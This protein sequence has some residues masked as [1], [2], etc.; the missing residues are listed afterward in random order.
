MGW[1][2][3]TILTFEPTDSKRHLKIILLY[4]DQ[5]RFQS[6]LLTYRLSTW[7]ITFKETQRFHLSIPQS[8]SLSG[9]YKLLSLSLSL[10]ESKKDLLYF[11]TMAATL[12]KSSCLLQPKSGSTTRLNP[13][14]VNP[15]PSPT[16]KSRWSQFQDKRRYSNHS[17]VCYYL[18]LCVIGVSVFGKS[19][20]DVVAKASIE[21]AES[22][23]FAPVK[24]N[25]PII[26]IDNYD[27][28]TYNLCQVSFPT[29]SNLRFLFGWKSA[30]HMMDD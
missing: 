22:T 6:K 25:G 18:C 17:R 13:S 29:M 3:A 8:R 30:A 26:V 20:R 5:T 16:S 10:S 7:F 28:F 4:F 23:P 14:L 15:H 24:Q 21:M 9:L 27:S 12:Y 19:R 11:P 2:H 1:V